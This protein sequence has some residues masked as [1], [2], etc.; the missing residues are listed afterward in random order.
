M[1]PRI[2]LIV[3]AIAALLFGLGPNDPLTLGLV[4]LVLAGATLLATW[5]PARRAGLMDE[6]DSTRRQTP[7]SS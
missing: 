7:V 2:V 3:G 1:V 6:G 5:V 4:A